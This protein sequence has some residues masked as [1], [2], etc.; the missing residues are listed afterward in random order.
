[1]LQ[2]QKTH[3]ISGLAQSLFE[4]ESKNRLQGDEKIFEHLFLHASA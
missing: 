2:A 1:M 4:D 3:A